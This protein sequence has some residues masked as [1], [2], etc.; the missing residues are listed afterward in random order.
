MKKKYLLLMMC[1]TL[2]LAAFCQ[3]GKTRVSFYN[4]DRLS[5]SL[6]F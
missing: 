6:F 5:L 4:G 3:E 2:S 1:I